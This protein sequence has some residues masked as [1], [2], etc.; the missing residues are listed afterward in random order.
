[1]TTCPSCL[2]S[3]L[4]PTTSSYLNVY[5]ELL[6]NYLLID[7]YDLIAK[8]LPVHCPS[9][10]YHAWAN[11][12]DG[13]LRRH[14][15]TNLLPSH[16]KG[17]DLRS[18]FFNLSA[19]QERLTS[20]ELSINHRRR[21]LDGYL[22]S[23]SFIDESE[24]L[25]VDN[26]FQKENA[27]IFADNM[28]P[29]IFNREPAP[30]SRYS[31]LSS[32]FLIDLV[33]SHLG[34]P[35][36]ANKQYTELGC[37]HWGLLADIQ[38]QHFK[39]FHV[40]PDNSIFWGSHCRPCTFRPA[41]SLSL[42]SLFSLPTYP[43]NRHV[44]SLFLILDHFPHPVNFVKQLF[45]SNITGLLIILEPTNPAFGLPI[46]HLSGWTVET[47]ERFASNMPVSSFQHGTIPYSSYIY[48]FLER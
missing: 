40:Q 12:I 21:L 5:S 30:Y 2:S 25:Y 47:L 38:K 29:I 4:Q 48:L 23:F 37:P 34:D 10:Q 11:P 26:L 41:P 39:T 1:M 35:S 8:C 9:C 28:L 16:P 46:Q 22:R 36:L 42:S 44:L 17:I 33:T 3:Y 31:G 15:Y 32:S 27:D 20:T 19:F 7:Q 24:H 6:A 43:A 18:N 13:L 14:I 45:C